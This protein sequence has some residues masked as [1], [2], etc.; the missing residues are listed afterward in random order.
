MMN[1][2]TDQKNNHCAR[3]CCVG[4]EQLAQ[5]HQHFHVG[6]IAAGLGFFLLSFMTFLFLLDKLWPTMSSASGQGV[7][8]L[9][10]LGATG[11]V[12]IAARKCSQLR[13]GMHSH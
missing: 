8:A 4:L 11:G 5:E 3:G 10:S 7:L 13:W 2:Y 12:M 6:R 9:L 1:G